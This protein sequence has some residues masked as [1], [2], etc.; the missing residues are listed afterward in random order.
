MAYVINLTGSRK[1]PWLGVDL[2]EGS[3][4]VVGDD[5]W[6]LSFQMSGTV[7]NRLSSAIRVDD[8]DIAKELRAMVIGQWQGAKVMKVRGR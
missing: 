8:K 4:S 1:G 2:V 6:T 3:F 7:A 5:D